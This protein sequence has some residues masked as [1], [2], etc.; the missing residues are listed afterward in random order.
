MKDSAVVGVFLVVEPFGLGN[1]DS[2]AHIPAGVKSAMVFFVL[3]LVAWTVDKPCNVVST[4]LLGDRSG[5]G[6]ALVDRQ[7]SG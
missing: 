7:S 4:D 2:V 6:L 3:Q 5:L 1:H